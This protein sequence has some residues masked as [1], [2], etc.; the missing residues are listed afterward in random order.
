MFNNFCSKS[1][2]L[3]QLNKIFFD[4]LEYEN[5]YYCVSHWSREEMFSRYHKE[6]RGCNIENDTK[7]P[8]KRIKYISKTRKD[9]LIG[10][11]VVDPPSNF[12]EFSKNHI[13][14]SI[15]KRNLLKKYQLSTH[16]SSFS[17]SGAAPPLPSSAPPIQPPPPDSTPPTTP[18][19]PPTEQLGSPMKCISV[20]ASSS[21]SIVKGVKGFSQ[22]NKLVQKQF[23]A[24]NQKG[25]VY[26]FDKSPSRPYISI[27]KPKKI[28]P[29]CITNV[30]NKG[31]TKNTKKLNITH[32][33]GP[34]R[35]N[36]INRKK[37]CS[38]ELITL[39]DNEEE[40]ICIKANSEI[41]VK[42]ENL[43]LNIDLSP[44]QSRNTSLT[45]K[46]LPQEGF[47]KL[48]EQS[49]V[50][51]VKNIPLPCS[52]KSKKSIDTQLKQKSKDIKMSSEFVSKSQPTSSSNN[53]REIVEILSE[54]TTENTSVR[55]KSNDAERT[56]VD[57]KI[58][59][60]KKNIVQNIC[61]EKCVLDQ[62]SLSKA[63]DYV[64]L[65]VSGNDNPHIYISDYA[66]HLKDELDNIRSWDRT[67]LARENSN[68]NGTQFTLMSYNILSQKLLTD[69]MFLYN[70]CDPSHIEW[71]YRWKL[72]KYEFTMMDPD[73]LTLQEVQCNHYQE[74]ILPWFTQQGYR[75]V[76]KKRT[77]DK[78]DGCA[79][80]Y[81]K[82]K[83]HLEES[84]S[85][86]YNQPRTFLDRDNI[87]LICSL[88]CKITKSV[89]CVG[90][91]HLLFNPKRH[92]IKLAQL[93]MFLSEVE[94][95]SYTGN[96]KNELAYCPV[97]ITGDMNAAP[98]T[99]VVDFIKQG[100]LKYYGL[101][102]KSLTPHGPGRLLTTNLLPQSLGVMETSQHVG[103]VNV[104]MALRN[105]RFVTLEQRRNMER[106]N[107]HLYHSQKSSLIHPHPPVNVPFTGEQVHP[108]Y[109]KSVYKH[110]L[111]RLGGEP[112]ITTA[113]N[114]YRTVD[115]IFY[116]QVI[117]TMPHIL[118]RFN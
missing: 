77:G 100:V 4:K 7:R 14:H 33:F 114:N 32:T 21:N 10:S 101:C 68:F 111:Y 102:S 96:G 19:P 105:E 42:N 92:D 113:A 56:K 99:T 29:S 43:V 11:P 73:I 47:E 36:Y 50:E 103:V 8:S 89:F 118:I 63:A 108:Y 71:E 83:F 90:T 49:C 45:D 2:F 22:S 117:I 51:F 39:S 12:G 60:Q 112:E 52:D 85:V 97:I 13:L 59:E 67:G 66:L 5:I 54:D 34:L 9:E 15:T 35:G 79:I 76:Y 41:L 88:S 95:L 23:S 80:F 27:N 57:I 46:L 109:L 55:K 78:V 31:Q 72:L 74:N 98:H 70:S 3:R 91:T 110:A 116:S 18:P 75:G 17:P 81:R 87:G 53:T 93:I 6:K 44:N 94:R 20:S 1:P 106:D 58:H 26:F 62:A 16:S 84:S 48:S 86:E 40:I 30:F 64:A 107:I 82:N 69:N 25:E 65:S 61:I 37:A 28:R 104:R 38:P 24:Q 115:Y